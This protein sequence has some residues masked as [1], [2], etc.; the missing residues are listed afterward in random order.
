[1]LLPAALPGPRAARFSLAPGLAQMSTP[2]ANPPLPNRGSPHQHLSLLDSTSII[3]GI[4]IGSTIYCSTPLIAGQVPNVG[5]LVAV[6]VLGAVFT[7][8]G[9]LCYAEWRPPIPRRAATTS[10]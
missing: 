5:W 1:M 3:V 7:L 4:I 8:I 9:A 6:W 2:V 10:S